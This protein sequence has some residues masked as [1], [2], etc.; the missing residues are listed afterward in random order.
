MVLVLGIVIPVSVIVAVGGSIGAWYIWKKRK[1]F[2]QTKKQYEILTP[3]YSPG[4]TPGYT[5]VATTES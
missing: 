1:Q 3:G 5:P 2:R 4:Y